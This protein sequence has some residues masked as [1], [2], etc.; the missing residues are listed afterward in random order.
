MGMVDIVLATRNETKALQIGEALHGLPVRV[1]TLTEAGVRGEAVEDGRTL[2]VNAL[3]KAWY[4][5]ERVLEWCLADDTGIFIDALHGLP[6]VRSGRWAGNDASTEDIM[7]HTL[8]KLHGVPAHKRTATF[9]TAAALV[10]PN[11]WFKVFVGEVKGSILTEPRVPCEPKMPYSAIFVP[12]GQDKVWAELS[13]EEKNTIGHR[14]K[15]FKQVHD[16]LVHALR[17]Y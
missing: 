2:E 6:G 8:R 5:R 10:A 7:Q 9:K 17:N 11:G 14:G 12:D 13:T 1:R 15:A 4:A 3:K 16:F